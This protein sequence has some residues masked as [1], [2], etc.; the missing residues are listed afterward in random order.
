LAAFG[1]AA[2]GFLA[3]AGFFLT[4]FFLVDVIFVGGLQIEQG[5]LV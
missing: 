1:L 5:R 3:D 2:A 4:T